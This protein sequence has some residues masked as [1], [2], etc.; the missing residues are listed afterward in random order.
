MEGASVARPP[1]D[2]TVPGGREGEDPPTKTRGNQGW[3][4][5]RKRGKKTLVG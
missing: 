2:R 5:F 1:E 3:T 4:T